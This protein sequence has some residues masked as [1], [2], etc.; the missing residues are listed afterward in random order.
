MDD[1]VWR[2]SIAAVRDAGPFSDFP[3][4]DRILSV[5]EGDLSL[6]VTGAP[7]IRLDPAAAPFAFPADIPVSGAPI[8]GDVRD[9]NV[10]V[11]RGQ[12]SATVE[13]L[14]AGTARIDAG[15]EGWLMILATGDARVTHDGEAMP[16]ARYD[17]VLVQSPV[18]RAITVSSNAPGFAIRLWV[19]S[20]SRTTSPEPV[21]AE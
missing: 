6:S 1:F 11:R 14:A 17:A 8:G 7:E 21:R 13:R 3:G 15:D 2:V 4:I 20:A 16:L 5:L 9:L 10:M 19:A 12:C 18:P